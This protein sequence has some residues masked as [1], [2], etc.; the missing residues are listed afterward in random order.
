[1]AQSG[2]GDLLLHPGPGDKGQGSNDYAI[3]HHID[4]GIDQREPLLLI[5]ASWVLDHLKQTE[6]V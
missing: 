3:R 5:E 1:M 2:D 6:D 4:V